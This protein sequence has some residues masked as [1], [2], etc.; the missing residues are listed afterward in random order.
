MTAGHIEYTYDAIAPVFWQM[1]RAYTV[2]VEAPPND[3]SAALELVKKWVA[4]NSNRPAN[5]FGYT[6]RNAD[7]PC[8][9]DDGPYID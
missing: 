7:L 4:K 8:Y 5:I 2:T 3:Q 6:L 1:P 9:E